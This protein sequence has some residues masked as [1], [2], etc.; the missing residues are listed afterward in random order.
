MSGHKMMWQNLIMAINRYIIAELSSILNNIFT[1]RNKGTPADMRNN[2]TAIGLS[3]DSL[4]SIV[5]N[6]PCHDN[7]IK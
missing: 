6:F 4:I 1:D 2:L 5:S 3:G 7:N